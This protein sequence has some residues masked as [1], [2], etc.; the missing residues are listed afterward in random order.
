MKEE[1]PV[2]ASIRNKN[3]KEKLQQNL[4]VRKKRIVLT[5][6]SL[7]ADISEKSFSVNHKV[8]ILNF[9]GE[10]V[11]EKLEKIIK[12]NPDNLIAHVGINDITN[13]IN[14]LSNVKKIFSKVSKESPST[15]IAFSSIYNCKDKT[16]IDKTLTYMNISLKNLCMQKGTSF[17][18]NSSIKEFYL[19]KRKLHLNKNGNS[20]FCKKIIASYKQEQERKQCLCKKV[21]ASY[22][23]EQKRKQYLCK[24]FIAL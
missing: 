22:K 10:K 3:K 9:T 8:K 6:D 5:G 23:Q 7:V 4:P 14:L 11:L 2:P 13:N 24:K 20:G 16:N 15:S 21:F 18:D 1:T 17:I 19:G 12:E